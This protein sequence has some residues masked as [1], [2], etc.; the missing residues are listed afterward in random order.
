MWFVSLQAIAVSYNVNF[1]CSMLRSLLSICS[2]SPPRSTKSCMYGM[3]GYNKSECKH[4][5]TWGQIALCHYVNI[6]NLQAILPDRWVKRD[7][8][9]QP[10]GRRV[11]RKLN[12]WVAK[13]K[14]L[15]SGS[16]KQLAKCC[17]TP[18]S[19]VRAINA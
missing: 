6:G 13:F 16:G 17:V 7:V 3:R 8:K 5:K 1:A 9:W 15:R 11:G 10:R 4:Q 2:S 19:F 18:S 14:T 12:T